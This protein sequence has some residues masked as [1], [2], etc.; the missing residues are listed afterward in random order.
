MLKF[1]RIGPQL[2][3]CGTVTLDGVQP[4]QQPCA[5]VILQRA[6]T[7]QP[8]PLQRLGSVTH[9][10]TLQRTPAPVPVPTPAGIGHSVGHG[11]TIVGPKAIRPTAVFVKPAQ[12]GR[13]CFGYQN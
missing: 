9:T 10:A 7:V 3:R 8:Q 13:A 6:Q 12:A 1:L 11:T 2:Q 5:G 4:V